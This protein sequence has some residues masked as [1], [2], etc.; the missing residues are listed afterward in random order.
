MKF[1]LKYAKTMIKS[2]TLCS[3]GPGLEPDAVPDVQIRIHS[4]RYGSATLMPSY[5]FFYL[6]PVNRLKGKKL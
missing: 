5:K 4:Q 3:L 1:L 2:N 6:P